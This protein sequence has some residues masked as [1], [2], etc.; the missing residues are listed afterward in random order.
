MRTAS[1]ACGQLKIS[2]DGEPRL[3]ALCHCLECQ[4]RTGSTYVIAAFFA[5]SAVTA[6][7]TAST[8]KAIVRRR[9]RG[10]VPFLPGVRLQRL[11]RARAQA[12]RDR[13]GGGLFCGSGVSGADARCMGGEKACVDRRGGD[14][15]T[16]NLPLEGKIERSAAFVNRLGAIQSGSFPALRMLTGSLST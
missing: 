1:C 7:E 3:V 10:H 16:A 6:E 8:Y 4:R 5:R 12:G 11:L 13:D 2:C 9:P 14:G 15:G